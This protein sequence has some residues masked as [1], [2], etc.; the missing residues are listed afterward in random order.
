MSNQKLNLYK[1]QD[2]ITNKYIAAAA[3]GAAY[4]ND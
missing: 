4:N 2:Y 1:L 3:V